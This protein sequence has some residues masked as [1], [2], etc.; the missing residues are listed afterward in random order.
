MTKLVSVIFLFNLNMMWFSFMRFMN[1]PSSSCPAPS[2]SNGKTE[3]VIKHSLLGNGN[4]YDDDEISSLVWS[5]I[6]STTVK[7]TIKVKSKCQAL[8]FQFYS[9]PFIRLKLATG[10]RQTRIANVKMAWSPTTKLSSSM[11]TITVFDTRYVNEGFQMLSKNKGKSQTIL[12]K[13]ITVVTFDPNFQQLIIGSLDFATATAD[14]NK[15]KFY[16]NF[17]EIEM[18]SNSV[19]GFM[20]ITWETHAD[21]GQSLEKITWDVF[22]FPRIV[23]VEIQ[24]RVGKN[25]FENM[26]SILGKKY[27]KD[28]K[29]QQQLEDI[30]FAHQFPNDDQTL[31]TNEKLKEIKSDMTRLIGVAESHRISS[32]MAQ[33]AVAAEADKRELIEA[34]KT[35]DPSIIAEITEKHKQKYSSDLEVQRSVDGVAYIGAPS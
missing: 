23:A 12:G 35:N 8:D 15:I 17:D 16:I 30:H 26:K 2:K 25:F 18:D 6:Q 19:F 32:E 27:E 24:L 4:P 22:T 14:I 29:R 9:W 28:Q 33:L 21:S 20:D 31:R 11:V 5:G 34:I 13:L 10:Q 3:N 1:N 7:S